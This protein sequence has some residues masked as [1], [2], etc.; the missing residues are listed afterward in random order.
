MVDKVVR[1][2]DQTI[3]ENEGL[4]ELKKAEMDDRADIED[5]IYPA[6]VSAKALTTD[7]D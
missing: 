5:M 6:T 7:Q 2:S 3:E 1:V 4:C